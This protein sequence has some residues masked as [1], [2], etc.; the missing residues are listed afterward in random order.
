MLLVLGSQKQ[1]LKW[2]LLEHHVYWS[3]LRLPGPSSVLATVA[4]GCAHI[5]ARVHMRSENK[6]GLQT[7]QSMDPSSSNSLDLTNG[8]RGYDGS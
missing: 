4:Q 1:S 8:E 7:L 2:Q 3:L 5:S 6:R